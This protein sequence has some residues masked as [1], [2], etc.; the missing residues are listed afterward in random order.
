[1]DLD[2]LDDMASFESADD[3]DS[4][5]DDPGRNGGH[6]SGAKGQTLALRAAQHLAKQPLQRTGADLDQLLE[7]CYR[8][9]FSETMRVAVLCAARSAAA[10]GCSVPQLAQ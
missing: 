2:E 1:M 6:G 5:G 8:C 4:E 10:C 9:V 3:T 7:W